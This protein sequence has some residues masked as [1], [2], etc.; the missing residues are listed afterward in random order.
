MSDRVPNPCADS[1][2][3]RTCSDSGS[4][5]RVRTRFDAVLGVAK[6][7]AVTRGERARLQAATRAALAA[8]ALSARHEAMG[9]RGR[10][11]EPKRL[12]R[13]LA[14]VRRALRAIGRAH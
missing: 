8:E 14:A 4:D 11:V 1:V 9:P 13:L 12:A 2:M 3:S 5:T 6:P 7:P 10:H